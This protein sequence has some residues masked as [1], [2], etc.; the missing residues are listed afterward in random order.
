ML[1]KSN[2]FVWAQ[3]QNTIHRSKS[4]VYGTWEGKEEEQ[5]SNVFVYI[6]SQTQCIMDVSFVLGGGKKGRRRR[7]KGVLLGKSNAN[8]FS[9]TKINAQ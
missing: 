7:R 6:L 1:F 5:E 8:C 3:S 2:A 9:I 4:F